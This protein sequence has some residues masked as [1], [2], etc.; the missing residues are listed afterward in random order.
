MRDEWYESR[1]R[2]GNNQA[3]RFGGPEP[4]RAGSTLCRRPRVKGAEQLVGRGLERPAPHQLGINRL[5][6]WRFEERFA[7][8]FFEQLVF[9]AVSK[10][11]IRLFWAVIRTSALPI[12]CLQRFLEFSSSP[13]LPPLSA[14][15]EFGH[16]GVGDAEEAGPDPAFFGAFLVDGVDEA[17]QVDVDLA[18]EVSDQV[19]EFVVRRRWSG[20]R[21][22]LRGA[23]RAA[24]C[25]RRRCRGSSRPGRHW[26][27]TGASCRGC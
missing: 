26:P 9:S 27:R 2:P 15:D 5:A 14:E 22:G 3:V 16:R 25:R 13:F 20:S 24:G 10:L 7:F 23:F 18:V 4:G 12:T 8:F 1:E 17:D 11:L 21:P 19:G 6:L